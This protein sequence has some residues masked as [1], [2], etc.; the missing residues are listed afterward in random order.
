MKRTF[1]KSKTSIKDR[2]PHVDEDEK[3]IKSSNLPTTPTK[4]STIK[5]SK[6]GL[7]GT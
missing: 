1:V 3:T 4:T 2:K 5:H 7:K 6:N